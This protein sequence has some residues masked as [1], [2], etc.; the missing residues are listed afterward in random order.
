MKEFI[1]NVFLYID[2]VC[3]NVSLV[4]DFEF[5]FNKMCKSKV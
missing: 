2:V 4:V 5:S 3:I 1:V